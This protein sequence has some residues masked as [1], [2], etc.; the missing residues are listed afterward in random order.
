MNRHRVTVVR[1]GIEIQVEHG[2]LH[3]EAIAFEAC[4]DAMHCHGG[5][6]PPPRPGRKLALLT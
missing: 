2:R 6:P 3:A 5:T 1:V 4:G